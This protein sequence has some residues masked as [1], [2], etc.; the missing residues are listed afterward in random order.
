MKESNRLVFSRQ[1][2]AAFIGICVRTLDAAR[3]NGS[4]G[5]IKLGSGKKSRVLLRRVDLETFL[6]R[7]AI[8]ARADC[9]TGI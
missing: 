9:I 8:A 3:A 6:A 7:H 1:E 5:F 4:L 2:A